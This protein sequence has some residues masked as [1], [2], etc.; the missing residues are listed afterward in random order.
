MAILGNMST[1]MKW[2]IGTVAFI[3]VGVLGF[4]GYNYWDAKA[5][6]VPARAQVDWVVDNCTLNRSGGRHRRSREIGPMPCDEARLKRS[7]GYSRYSVREHR[8]IGYTFTSPADGQRHTGAI[9][10][11]PRD[12]PDIR[13][14]SVIDILAHKTDPE[15]S[16]R[17]L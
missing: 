10:A 9:D 3:L 14:G 16:R 1:S 6:Y 8:H 5:H 15:K 12:Y 17:P 11:N 2:V 4:V 7:Q 13:A